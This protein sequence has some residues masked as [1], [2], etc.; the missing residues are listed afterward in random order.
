[1]DTVAPTQSARDRSFRQSA[2]RSA[3][4]DVLVAVPDDALRQVLDAALR[5]DGYRVQ[6]APAVAG[7]G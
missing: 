5:L 7:W 4:P 2:G 1:M 6:T 3:A